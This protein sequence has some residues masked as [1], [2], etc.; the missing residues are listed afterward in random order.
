MAASQ[1]IRGYLRLEDSL[2]ERHLVKEK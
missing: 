1:L 2:Y